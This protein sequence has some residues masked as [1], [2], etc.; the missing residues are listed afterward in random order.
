MRSRSHSRSRSRSQS[1]S[2]VTLAAMG[3]ESDAAAGAAKDGK[4]RT[5]TRSRGDSIAR[6]N[7]ASRRSSTDGDRDIARGSDAGREPDTAAILVDET[8]AAA[9]AAAVAR[10]ALVPEEDDFLNNNSNTHHDN[11]NS[12]NATAQNTRADDSKKVSTNGD[13]DSCGDDI[14]ASA[15]MNASASKP[16]VTFS[17]P[18][19]DSKH[20]QQSQSE[21]VSPPHKSGERRNPK[22]VR[23]SALDEGTF[24]H[25]TTDEPNTSK[26]TTVTFTNNN[27]NS[28]SVTADTNT[29]TLSPRTRARTLA[30]SSAANSN[31]NSSG[32]NA[33]QTVPSALLDV[34]EL[35]ADAGAHT[36]FPIESLSVTPVELV[37]PSPDDSDSGAGVGSKTT[38]D[39]VGSNSNQTPHFVGGAKKSAPPVDSKDVELEVEMVP[40]TRPPATGAKPARPITS[41][42]QK[43]LV[44]VERRAH[45]TEVLSYRGVLKSYAPRLMQRIRG[46]EG[47]AEAEYRRALSG[48]PAPYISLKTNSRSGELFFLT[49]DRKYILKTISASETRLMLRYILA[50]YLHLRTFPYSLVN[51][52]VGM[53]KL[54][55]RHDR[56]Q[57][58]GYSPTDAAATAAEPGN[59]RGGRGNGAA[60]K[61][62]YIECCNCCCAQCG[63]CAGGGS[64]SSRTTVYRVIVLKMAYPSECKLSLQFDL[65]GST[66]RRFVR[67]TNRII[68][69]FVRPLLICHGSI[70]CSFLTAFHL[71]MFLF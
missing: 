4:T 64:R 71:F 65:K 69:I 67:A 3:S 7:S 38:A 56:K 27:S 40:M 50:Y 60:S 17:T 16:T 22:G 23:V 33:M 18:S 12:D 2:G 46:L 9:E 62:H 5:R 49:A 42:K 20:H 24:I 51:R 8:E 66:D 11:S 58:C 21:H 48:D 61:A 45:T 57:C 34:D 6:R 70:I 31:N 68:A 32:G 36:R 41:G 59:V 37:V 29:N 30:N 54:T 55:V 10:L 53:Y 13:A 15:A 26:T 39:A 19:K 47:I 43:Q 52:V 35:F 1:G 14:T 63:G 28:N 25:I 44:A